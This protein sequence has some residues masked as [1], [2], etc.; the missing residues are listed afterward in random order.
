MNGIEGFLLALAAASAALYLTM[1]GGF[2]VTM[3]RR[4]EP[5][6]PSRRPRVSILKPLA[7]ADDELEENL[8][9]FAGLAYPEYEIVLGVASVEDAAFAAARRF[10]RRVGGH[11]A[12]LIV[13]DPDAATNPKV[14][15]LL[16]L[17]RVATGEIVVSRTRTFG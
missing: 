4:S 12:R 11:R 15:Q 8:A 10:V 7:G 5:P 3:L 1:V 6:Q 9:S 13:T 16:A 2:V 14:A 17:E